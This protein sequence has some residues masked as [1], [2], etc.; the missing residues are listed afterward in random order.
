MASRL[1]TAT[2]QATTTGFNYTVSSGSNRALIV[3]IE[4]E[5]TTAGTPT[6]TY[7]T[8]SMTLVDEIEVNPGTTSQR[9]SLLWCNDATIEAA[10]TTAIA[11][12]NVAGTSVT[13]H[14]ASYEEVSQ[15]LTTNTNTDSSAAAT[16]NPLVNADITTGAAS[17]VVIS[18]GGMGNSGTAAWGG[19]NPLTEQT[20]Q[21]D[22]GTTA[23]GS[24]ADREQATAATCQC[25]CTWT[26]PNRSAKVS[27]ELAHL[28]SA[29]VEQEGYRW[30][31][32]GT[33]SG[34]T[35]RQDQDTVDTVG[36]EETVQLRVLLDATGDPATAQYRLDY[37]ET[38]DP[39]TE[40]RQVPLT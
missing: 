2:A 20:E 5:G 35:V 24:F 7:G 15:T 4:Q 37:K 28:A 14:A 12:S 17:A 10:S 39:D 21:V 29:S 32:D 36:Q 1:D 30:Y 18:L 3:G 33:E 25:R 16:P 11:V 27:A 34:S 22:T 13:V 38:S 9:V 8:Q 19:T 31:D 23:T 40:Y 26:T 6:A